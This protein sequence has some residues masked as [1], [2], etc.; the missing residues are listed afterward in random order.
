MRL[1]EAVSQAAGLAIP[2]GGLEEDSRRMAA[3]IAEQI[4]GTAEIQ[5][6]VDLLEQQ[7]DENLEQYHEDH[8][9]MALP[10]HSAEP[11]P[12]GDE[13]GEEFERFL[14]ALDTPDDSADDEDDN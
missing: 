4:Q 2:L 11:M 14:A 5:Q 1:L 13:L 8:P 12:S 6:V 7:Y 10:G 3:Q 9:H